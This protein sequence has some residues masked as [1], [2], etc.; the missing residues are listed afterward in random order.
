MKTL[1]FKA[2]DAVLETLS[3]SDS[4]MARL[5]NTVGDYELELR[6]DYFPALVRSIIGQQLS[7]V[8][9]Q[10]IWERI[11]NLCNDVNPEVLAGISA[12]ELKAAGLSGT[13]TGYIKD[14][15]QRV[16]SEELDLTR[17]DSLP[18]DEVIR[19][20]VQIKG[21]GVWTAE[22][23]LIFSLG[24]P[25]VFSLGDLGLRRSIQWLYGYK[26]N[27]ADRTLNLHSRKWAPYR[28]IA[29]LYLWEV[30]NRG[31]IKNSPQFEP[32]NSL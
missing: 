27:P 16:L 20:L 14:L 8:V 18:N 25:D 3:S 1:S 31:L 7:V 4:K 29:S 19:R 32:E 24:R 26:K 15:S 10:T 12:A 23:F 2:G 5:I 17:L 21:I 6:T 28:S 9:A 11:K 13:K 30:I 22:M